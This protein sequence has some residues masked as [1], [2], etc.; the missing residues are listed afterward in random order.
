MMNLSEKDLEI[1]INKGR[2]EDASWVLGQLMI[3]GTSDLVPMNE[4]KGLYW[5]QEAAKRNHLG[6]IEAKTYWEIR[7]EKSPNIDEIVR[8][9][10]KVAQGNKS[11]KACNTLAELHHAS[12]GG[13][14][15]QTS[16]EAVKAA[17][18]KK[19][20]ANNYYKISASQGDVIGHHWTGV[21]AME[22]FGCK[23][24]YD[25]AIN[26]LTKAANLGNCQS[27]FQLY[28][29][30]SGKEGMP[31]KKLKNPE[32]A[33]NW[34]IKGIFG[35]CTMFDE[36]IT[37]FKQHYAILA[38]IYVASKKLPI[39]VTPETEQDILNMHDANINELKSSFSTAL[40]K[41]RMY[42]RP[43]GFLNDQQIWMLGI[44]TQYMLNSVL[45]FSHK[46]FLKALR[47]DL[48]PVLGDTGMWSLKCL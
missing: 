33:Y 2:N 8:N 9:L 21:F 41:D 13:Q 17:A 43:C 45:R 6:A 32:K 12:V 34:L 31:Q 27:M 37:F 35:G 39:E 44:Q 48:G 3:D 23:V 24:D 46:D 7:F 1:L 42:H 25:I 29:L 20:L 14:T 28:L 15:A 4:K 30:H 19:E 10:E 47:V 36:A 26:N 22:G 18:D 38:P 16:P 40:G 5:L 11:P